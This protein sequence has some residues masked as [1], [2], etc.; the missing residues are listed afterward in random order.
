MQI[1]KFCISGD[2]RSLEAEKYQCKAIVD[3]QY[4]TEAKVVVFLAQ[5][6]IYVDFQSHFVEIVGMTFSLWVEI[7]NFHL[8]IQ[9][10]F[11]GK[12]LFC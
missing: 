7:G 1:N 3:F 5:G 12:N 4:G 9:I 11:A 10:P 6:P 8:I 2:K